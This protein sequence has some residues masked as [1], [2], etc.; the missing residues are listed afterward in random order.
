MPAGSGPT[1]F[2]H[3]QDGLFLHEPDAPQQQLRFMI[4]ITI[5]ISNL[6]YPVVS[7][8]DPSNP[9]PVKW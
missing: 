1:F 6:N 7:I 4:I 3:E 5:I 9:C 2:W 8:V